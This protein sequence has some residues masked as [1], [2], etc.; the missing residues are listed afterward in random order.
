MKHIQ[1]RV[2]FFD[3]VDDSAVSITQFAINTD[4][5][6]TNINVY[7]SN[8]YIA[9]WKLIIGVNIMS[10]SVLKHPAIRNK[11]ID[12]IRGWAALSVVAFHFFVELFGNITPIF[13]SEWFGFILDDT[14]AVSIFFILSGDA[15]SIPFFSKYSTKTTARLVLSRYFRLTFP[16]AICCFI[17]FI[18]M[19]LGFIFNTEAAGIVG[20]NLWLDQFLQFQ[21][22]LLGVVRYSFY[23][24]YFNHSNEI[25]YNPFLWTISIEM[26]GSI[27][28]FLNIFIFK[29]IKKPL[30]VLSVQ[31]IFFFL[32]DSP[33]FLFIIGMIMGYFRQQGHFERVLNKKKNGIKLF[34]FVVV[35][36][37]ISIVSK[38]EISIMG[39]ELKRIITINRYHGLW[40]ALVLYLMYSSKYLLLFFRSK[41]SHFL[42]EISFPLYVIQFIILVSVSSWAIIFFE[43]RGELHFPQIMIIATSSIIL[44]IIASILFREVEKVYLKQLK[45]VLLKVMK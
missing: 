24:V 29:Y 45:R 36:L 32:F 13:H 25:S 4:S 12:G 2:C 40:A 35:A 6:F 10:T 39:M 37:I 44:S 8:Q 42:G 11:E 31:C 38:S 9:I 26:L 43:N 27:I 41:L 33:M 3:S 7:Y 28:I 5:C 30:L 15:L 18:L 17:V 23:D 16:V 22:S 14:L 1:F 19:K 20:S 21:P 34:Y